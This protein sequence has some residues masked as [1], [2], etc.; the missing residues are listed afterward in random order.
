[1]HSEDEQLQAAIDYLQ[2]CKNTKIHFL[3]L[4]VH[5]TTLIEF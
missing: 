4:F 5:Q 2:K 3:R 1:M